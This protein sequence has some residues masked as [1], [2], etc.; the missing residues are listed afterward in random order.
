[1]SMS[2]CIVE[3]NNLEDNIGLVSEFL[4]IWSD[5]KR[6]YPGEQSVKPS[7]D[8][9][10]STETE[11]H[12]TSSRDQDP[13]P[14]FE[15]RLKNLGSRDVDS[16]LFVDYVGSYTIKMKEP[17][18]VDKEDRQ[19]SWKKRKLSSR[20]KKSDSH[21]KVSS[22]VQ[23][24]NLLD[25]IP[26]KFDGSLQ[27]KLLISFLESNKI[28][29]NSPP[30]IVNVEA[31]DI[32]VENHRSDDDG[33]VVQEISEGNSLIT[34]SNNNS[35]VY[36]VIDITNSSG[37]SDSEVEICPHQDEVQGDHVDQYSE[38]IHQERKL[39]DIEELSE[40]SCDEGHSHALRDYKHPLEHE[41]AFWYFFPTPGL[42]WE[43]NLQLMVTVSTIEDF[44]S[45]VNWVECP[46]SMKNGADFSL[47]KSGIE[48]RKIE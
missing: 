29:N 38:E 17:K 39:S 4:N 46:S 45:V 20:F 8:A 36:N 6:F 31:P 40:G 3:N 1:M 26:E 27:T 35:I 43:E 33:S 37:D 12:Q 24:D 14:R 16:N 30:N 9:G 19:T 5:L 28:I 7:G 42:C 11:N 44:W 34:D 48:I 32:G 23:N 10:R 2:R 18:I 21:G 13:A 25:G 15:R 22:I 47:F 41:W